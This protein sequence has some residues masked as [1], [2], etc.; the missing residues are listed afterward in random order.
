MKVKILIVYFVSIMCNSYAFADDISGYDACPKSDYKLTLNEF[1]S[2]DNPRGVDIT[3]E[4]E[5]RF[6]LRVWY[7]LDSVES[8]ELCEKTASY[9]AS[10]SNEIEFIRKEESQY[11]GVGIEV[12]KQFKNFVILSVLKDGP[13]E[14]AG[15]KVNDQILMINEES[16]TNLS[17]E[18]GIKMIGGPESTNIRLKIYRPEEMNYFEVLLSR[19][20]LAPASVT[21]TKLSRD[22]LISVMVRMPK[23]EESNQELIEYWQGMANQFLFRFKNEAYQCN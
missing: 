3:C 13:S 17:F 10:N 8:Q 5:K 7:Y 11:T 16:V 9:I 20:L 19:E 1:R 21:L 23:S 2:F 14:K 4:Y 18:E 15:I 6:T 22:S 12:K